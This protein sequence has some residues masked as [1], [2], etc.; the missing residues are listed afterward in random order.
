ML[1]GVAMLT[2]WFKR[3]LLNLWDTLDIWEFE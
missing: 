1:I 3:N 2:I